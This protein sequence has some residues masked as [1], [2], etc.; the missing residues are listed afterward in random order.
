LRLLFDTLG[1]IIGLHAMWFYCL[2]Y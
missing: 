1:M 2:I